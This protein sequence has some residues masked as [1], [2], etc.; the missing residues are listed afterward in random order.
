MYVHVR[1]SPCAGWLA[2]CL[3]GWLAAWLAGCLAGW[4]PGWQAGWVAGWLPAWLAGCLAGWP[5][6]W[7]AGLAWLGWLPGWLAVH[8]RP[9]PLSST[10]GDPGSPPPRTLPNAPRQ[11]PGPGLSLT[12]AGRPKKIASRAGETLIKTARVETGRP[13][14]PKKQCSRLRETASFC[15]RYAPVYVK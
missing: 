12:R 14:A 15:K 4:L 13:A 3:A 5:P 2:G 11:P 1:A 8:T 7:L 6:A 9:A 10:L